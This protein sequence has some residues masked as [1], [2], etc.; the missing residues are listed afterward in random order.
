MN[1]QQ[2]IQER[3]SVK[4]YDPAHVMPQS[5]ID[6]L[7]DL[8]MLTPTSFNMQNWRFLA[9]KNPE[10]RNKIKAAAWGQA[11]VTDASLLLIVCADLN[12]HARQPQRYWANAPKNV[13]DMIVPM[14]GKFYEGNATLQRDEAM[15]SAG[16]AAQTLM[17]AAKDMGYDSC[18]MVGFDPQKVA[19]LIHL[20][21]DHVIGMLIT[22]GK[23]LQPAQGRGG[24]LPKKEVMF[25]DTF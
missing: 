11:Q 3:R 9:V 12:A 16:L 15:R 8:A 13:Q 4:H 5:D 17:L 7:I 19:Q 6:K 1:T 18:P 23:A 22:I 20:P 24:Q 2:A 14:I 10:L 21:A 25:V